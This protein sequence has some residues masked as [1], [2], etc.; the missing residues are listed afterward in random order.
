[1]LGGGGQGEIHARHAACPRGVP[2]ETELTAGYWQLFSLKLTNDPKKRQIA[3]GAIA[4]SYFPACKPAD[5]VTDT[6]RLKADLSAQAL[7]KWS[8]KLEHFIVA[9]SGYCAAIDAAVQHQPHTTALVWG[10]IRFIIQVG[11]PL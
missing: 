6:R 8:E 9:L 7:G 3:A 1:M 5:L 11:A 4:K 2:L 10:G